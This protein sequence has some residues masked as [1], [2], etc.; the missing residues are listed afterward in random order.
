MR[1]TQAPW[2]VKPTGEGVALSFDDGVFPET[3]NLPAAQ[4]WQLTEDIRR[5]IPGPPQSLI[6]DKGS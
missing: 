2:S 4:A 6:P 3:F 5:F 1:I